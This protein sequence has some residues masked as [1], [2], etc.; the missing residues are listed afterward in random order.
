M[1]ARIQERIAALSM[2]ERA[3]I[4]ALCVLLAAG[5]FWIGVWRPIEGWS[6]QA[7]G[8]RIAAEQRLASVRS[9]AREIE[10]LSGRLSPLPAAELEARILRSADEAGIVLDRVGPDASGGVQVAVAAAS[11]TQVLAWLSSLQAD[12]GLFV[13][14]LSIVRAEDGLVSLDAT[15]SGG[16]R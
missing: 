2:R 6:N 9:A 15:L 3:L 4:A 10:G 12:Q 5:A 13:P 16:S 14:H 8:R 1:M 11:P 7:A